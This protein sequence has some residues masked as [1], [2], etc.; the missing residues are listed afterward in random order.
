MAVTASEAGRPAISYHGLIEIY[1][2]LLSDII[3]NDYITKRH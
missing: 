2:K 1:Y 3:V